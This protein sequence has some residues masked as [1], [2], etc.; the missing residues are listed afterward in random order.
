MSSLVARDLQLHLGPQLVLDGITANVGPGGRLAVVGPNGVGKTTLLRIL[1]GE[2]SADHG[3]VVRQPPSATVGLLPQERDARPDETVAAYLARRTGVAAA[4]AELSAATT[5]LADGVRG[6]DDRYAMALEQYLALGAADLDTRSPAVLAELGLDPAR[7]PDQVRDLS[8]GQL[9]R[10]ALASVLLARFDVLLLDEPTNDLDLAGLD[11][12]ERFLLGRQGGL[13]VVSHDRTFLERVVTDV[14]EI[15][16][17]TRAGHVYGG[18]FASY[19]EERERARALAQE[20]YEKYT[21]QRDA[22]VAQARRQQEW[23]RSGATRERRR[24]PDN[25]KFARDYQVNRTERSASSAARALRA[26]ERLE[27]VEEPRTPWELRLTL[28]QRS[29]SGDQVVELAGVVVERGEFRLGPVDLDLRYGDR[30]AL[31]GPNGGGKSTLIGVLLGTLPPTAGHRRLG[32]GVVPGEIDQVR[33]GVAPDLPLLDAFRQATGQDETEARALLAKFGLGADDVVRATG[34]L[35]PGE[36]T[37]ADLAL[38]V[39]RQANLLVLDEPTNHLDLPAVEQLEQALSAF[40]GTLV[41]ASHDR[42]LLEKVRPTQ[43]A[44]VRDGK[45]VLERV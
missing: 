26:A 34:S 7:L 23:A 35:S 37:R 15:D 38:L 44:H 43:L 21:A 39:A 42:R 20:A 10:L 4:D 1:A 29:R 36:R 45:V 33:R 6:A 27:V 18:G 5:A 3:A 22:L 25:D 14:L 19:L 30:L 13:V 9:A 24:P 28:D 8:G 2:L 32:N 41:L 17:F 31:V 40:D 12:L 11:Q 16:E